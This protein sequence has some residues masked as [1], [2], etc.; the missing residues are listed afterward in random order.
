MYTVLICDDDPDIVSALEI[1]L[2]SEGYRTRSACDGL[3]ALNTAVEE[4][5]A[6]SS[7][8]AIAQAYH[9]KVKAA[10]E[11]LRSASGK[12][13]AI[14]GDEYWPLPSYSSMLYYTM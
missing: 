11:A 6:Q 10:M 14:C 8:L 4:A 7:A 9:D 2:T 5:E 12:A 1:Y 13:E 3:E